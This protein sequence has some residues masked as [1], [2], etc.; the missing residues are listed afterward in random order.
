MGLGVAFAAAVGARRSVLPFSMSCRRAGSGSNRDRPQ[1]LALQQSTDLR[2]P[3]PSVLSI[4]AEV[5]RQLGFQRLRPRTEPDLALAFRR[6][7]PMCRIGRDCARS[8]GLHP[9]NRVRTPDRRRR[10]GNLYVGSRTMN[11]EFQR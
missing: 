1:A 4:A 6:V 2:L 8:N 7:R 11:S 3:S 10:V 9:H 5:L